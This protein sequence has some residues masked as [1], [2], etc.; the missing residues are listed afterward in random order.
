M[1]YPII[2]EPSD[3][4]TSWGV[5][6]PDFP[7]CFSAGDNFDEAMENVIEVMT[8]WVEDWLETGNKIPPS[9]SLEK[10]QK[11]KD[12]KESNFIWGFAD[13]DVSLFDDKAERVNIT[14]P[15]PVLPA[16]CRCK[17][18]RRNTLKQYCPLSNKS[19]K[20]QVPFHASRSR[21]DENIMPR[22]RE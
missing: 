20:K 17:I 19:L 3:D 14:L 4:K 6:V 9:S 15:R 13:F 21:K 10:L 8:L 16:L 22:V 2:L 7:G 1:R 5:I 12:Y 18:F 11:N